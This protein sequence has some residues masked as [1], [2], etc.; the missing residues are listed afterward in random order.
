[1]PYYDLKKRLYAYC[2]SFRDVLHSFVAMPIKKTFVQYTLLLFISMF[3][4]SCNDNNEDQ[5]KY[6]IPFEIK[7]LTDEE[8]PDNPDI[9]FRAAGYRNDY[10][11]SGMLNIGADSFELGFSFYTRDNDTIRVTGVDVSEFIPTI[12]AHIQ[13]DDYLAYISCIN[14][15]WN[16]NQVRFMPDEFTSTMPQVT[17]VDIA[18]NCLNAYLWEVIV[19][20]DE[21][22]KT[23]PFAH[24]WFDFPHELYATLFEQKNNIPFTRYKEPLEEWRD[25]DSRVVNLTLLRTLVDTLRASVVDQSDIMYPLAG[26]RKKKYKEIIY[27]DTFRTMRNLQSDSTLFATFTPP[28]YYNRQDP[29]TTELGRIYKLDDG[30][31]YR[32]VSKASGDTLH[33]IKLTFS[34]RANERTTRLVIGGLSFDEFPVVKEE[35]ANNGWKSSMGIGNHTFYEGYKEHNEYKSG[36]SAYYAML[37]DGDGKWLDSHIIGIDGPIFHFSDEDRKTLHLWL[38]SFERHALVGHYVIQMK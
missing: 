27:P 17:R 23:V 1:M 28:G 4:N 35:D 37:L 19:Y 21:H 15:E 34:D 11:T 22:N 9:G 30:N 3:L 14:Q 33:E 18:R 31:I 26:A 20:T 6:K 10:F 2:L 24:G 8:Y 16:R 12:P 32:A 7:S 36:K 38:L 5:D 29:R 13:H 25:P